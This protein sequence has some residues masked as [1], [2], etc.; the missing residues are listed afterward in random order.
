MSPIDEISA[1]F[2]AHLSINRPVRLINTYRGVPVVNDAWVVSV[3]QGYILFSMQPNQVVCLALEG[4]TYVRGS[5]LPQVY[6]AKVIAVDVTKNQAILADF[7]G[8]G[9][10][11]GNRITLRVQPTE[12]IDAQIYDG[13][14]RIPGRLADVSSSGIGIFTLNTHFYGEQTI[15]KDREVIIDVAF[16]PT[17]QIARFHARVAWVVGQSDTYLYRVGMEI[18]AD[19]KTQPL[20]L[21][22]LAQRQKEIME[23]LER[24]YETMSQNPIV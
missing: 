4:Q 15:D 11:I 17:R 20:L 22:Y 19:Q 3:N 6:Q 7:V 5:A 8:M 13:D 12:P 1:A 23:E 21:R 18:L 24:V 9:D 16:P 10:S 2:Q 14:R